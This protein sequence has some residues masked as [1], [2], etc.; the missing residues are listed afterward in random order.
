SRTSTTSTPTLTTSSASV[1]P[2]VP[3]HCSGR[4]AACGRLHIAADTAA[5][6]DVGFRLSL[7]GSIS[8]ERHEHFHGATLRGRTRSWL[9]WLCRSYVIKQ[10]T[11]RGGCNWVLHEGQS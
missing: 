8:I 11:C 5:S 6:T 9:G 1:K 4:R 3:R 2:A 10:C 7:I